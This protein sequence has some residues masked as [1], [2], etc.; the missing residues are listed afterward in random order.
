MW[1]GTL[2]PNVLLAPAL[3]PCGTG[4]AS[5]ILF[6]PPWS[7]CSCCLTLFN[8]MDTLIGTLSFGTTGAR[9]PS[10]RW[11]RH[12]RI[13]G[14]P[15]SLRSPRSLPTA[16]FAVLFQDSD[17]FV[18]NARCPRPRRTY[19]EQRKS[20]TLATSRRAPRRLPAIWGTGPSVTSST[21]R[22]SYHMPLPTIHSYGPSKSRPPTQAKLPHSCR[23]D[24]A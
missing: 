23:L 6:D 13:P 12:V 5:S 16:R 11:L 14:F 2:L 17:V 4:H 7:H 20:P 19:R 21:L 1:E 15:D 3:C 10:P 24:R 9:I 22:Q 8:N 18:V